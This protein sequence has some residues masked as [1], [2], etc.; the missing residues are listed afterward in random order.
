MPKKNGK[1]RMCFDYRGLNKIT[2]KDKYPLPDAEQVIEQLDGAKY[3][4]QLD[5]SHGYHQLI[6]DPS[7]VE[8]TAFRTMFGAYEWKVMT[9]EML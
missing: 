2:V 4:S 8:K 6:L 1:F 5:L 7:D 3:F 9:V